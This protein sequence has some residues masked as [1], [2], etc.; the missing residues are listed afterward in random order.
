MTNLMAAIFDVKWESWQ[1]IVVIFLIVGIAL[2][3]ILLLISVI[4]KGVSSGE[5]EKR[6]RAKQ[7]ERYETECA[8][9]KEE[10]SKEKNEIEGQLGVNRQRILDKEHEAQAAEAE[11]EKV[12]AEIKAREDVIRVLLE[13]ANMTKK[14]LSEH[15]LK[16][17]AIVSEDFIINTL[18]SKVIAE[19]LIVMDENVEDDKVPKDITIQYSAAEVIKYLKNKNKVTFQDNPGKRCDVFKVN[20]T[21]FALLYPATDKGKIRLTIKCGPNY[22]NK[23]ASKYLLASV[24]KSK[25]P[26]GLLWFSVNGTASFE[27]IKLLIDIS[28]SL[29]KLGY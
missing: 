26:Y 17:D 8:T 3:V 7:I 13:S 24:E 15:M 18:T 11:A 5:M 22:G 16:T 29:A 1:D 28:Y 20:G 4:V 9:R 10:L 21:T 6:R 27:V 14:Q 12:R 25:F 23:L 19:S 2:V